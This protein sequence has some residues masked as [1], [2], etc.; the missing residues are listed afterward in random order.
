MLPPDGLTFIEQFMF[1]NY[2]ERIFSWRFLFRVP[3]GEFSISR[4]F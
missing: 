4:F 2:R 3:N 1:C